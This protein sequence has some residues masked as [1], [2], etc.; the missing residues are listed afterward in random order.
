[1]DLESIAGDFA[2]LGARHVVIFYDQRGAGR[3]TLPA[4]TTRLS[5][6]QQVA[7]LDAVRRHFG[8]TRVT[9]VAHSYGPLLA[10]T[11]AI[12][13]PQCPTSDRLL[14]FTGRHASV[15]ATVK[16]TRAPNTFVFMVT[17]YAPTTMQNVEI[18]VRPPEE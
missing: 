4:D 14:I 2:T 11:Y 3:S 7:D 12:V 16:P 6:T 17:G 1:M 13:H 18:V 9:L 5:A 8:L 10:A 15:T